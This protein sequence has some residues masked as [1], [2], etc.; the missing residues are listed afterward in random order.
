[1][2]DSLFSLGPRLFN[3]F[4][5]AVDECLRLLLRLSEIKCLP[6]FEIQPMLRTWLRRVAAVNMQ[7]TS[8]VD[9]SRGEKVEGKGDIIFL[10]FG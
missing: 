6:E 10:T 3:L 9:T 7:S 5:A 8:L 1:M 4:N 2:I